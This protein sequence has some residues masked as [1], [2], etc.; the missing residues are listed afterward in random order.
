VICGGN[1]VAAAWRFENDTENDAVILSDF[2]CLECYADLNWLLKGG[3]GRGKR[4]LE[5]YGLEMY[6]VLSQRVEAKAFRSHVEK[7]IF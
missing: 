6:E 2:P 1:V 7:E 5:S 4:R 3:E